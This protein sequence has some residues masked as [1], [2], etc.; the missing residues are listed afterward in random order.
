MERPPYDHWPISRRPRLELPGGA[1]VAFWLGVN[2]EHH[3][4][5]KPSTNISPVTAALVPDPLNAGWRDYGPRVGI[6]RMLDLLDERSMRASV[7]LSSD[8]C[9][10]YPEIVEEGVK[11][12]W[13]WLAHGKNHSTLQTHMAPGEERRYLRE[14]VETIASS[15]GKRPQGWLGPSL[16]E[17]HQTPEILAELG[18]T[19]LCDWCNDDQPYPL[20]V[21]RGRMI[22]VPY[23]VEVN[24]ISL[25]LGM[26]FT[27]EEYYQVVVDQFD[28]LYAE[29][30]RTARVM[31]LSLHPFIINQPFRHRYLAK[32]LDHV[33]AHDDVWVTTSDDI[34]A[35]YY[36]HYYADALTHLPPARA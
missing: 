10:H 8:V 2:V 23:S 27:A 16:S 7:P 3:V 1:R 34:A 18:L 13:V 24:D 20:R 28:Q 17:T 32:A 30:A 9:E 12:D 11:R 15:T 21:A 6:W 5:D 29:G 19:Y 26:H 22:S 4:Y 33:L 36:A 14:V 35:W 31:A 25:F